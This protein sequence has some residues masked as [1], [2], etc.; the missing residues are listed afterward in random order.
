MVEV[1]V[2]TT[3]PIIVDCPDFVKETVDPLKPDPVIT[4]V[5]KPLFGAF[6]GVMVEMMGVEAVVVRITD[7][8]TVSPSPTVTL[9]RLSRY[10]DFCSNTS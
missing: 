2:P 5:C 6:E 1:S 3:A 9:E 4:M 10:P 8:V 7:S